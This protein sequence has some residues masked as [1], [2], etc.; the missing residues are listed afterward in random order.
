MDRPLRC[1]RC[2]HFKIDCSFETSPPNKPAHLPHVDNA[3]HN[4]PV[5]WSAAPSPNQASHHHGWPGSPSSSSRLHQ[6]GYSPSGRS[7]APSIRM[8]SSHGESHPVTPGDSQT[9][10]SVSPQRPYEL[11]VFPVAPPSPPRCIEHI[12]Q[13]TKSSMEVFTIKPTWSVQGRPF[14]E[15]LPNEKRG[16][17]GCRDVSGSSQSY[18]LALC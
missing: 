1:K 10:V 13:D 14:M 9:V 6:A 4:G 17:P 3:T 2:A 11:P 12:H 15:P 18:S 5:P 16:N 8:E 7:S